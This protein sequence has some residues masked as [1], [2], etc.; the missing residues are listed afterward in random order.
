M[1]N[2]AINGFGRIGRSILRALL[3]Q[4]E[5]LREDMKHINIVAINDINDWQILS[6]LLAHDTT[7]GALPYEVTHAQNTLFIKDS[8]LP[9]IPTLN[10]ATPSEL[11]FSTFGADIV[12]ESSGQFLDMHSLEHHCQKG[13]KK[14][15][16]SAAPQDNMPMFALGVNHTLYNNEPIFSN[17]SCTANALAPLCKIID[18]HFGIDL[19]S[20]CITH[21]YTNE[22]SLLDSVYPHDKRRS[23]AAAQ[24]IIP[25]STGATSALLRLL[26]SLQGKVGGHSVRVPVSN[27]LLLDISFVLSRQANAQAINKRIIHESEHTMRGIIGI[28]RDYGVSSDFIGN[29]HSVV[30]VPDLTY[31]VSDKMVRIMAWCDN[32][33]GYANRMLDMVRFCSL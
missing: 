16:L 2:I 18:E 10:C 32:E 13:I 29:P 24:N 4:Q 3:A 21:S 12:I 11:D 22:Q 5:A 20:F 19:A 7:H 27:V 28:D 30:F 1:I 9:P 17:A 6:Y 23:R 8:P 15:I 31:M 26:P 25:T 33:W 14:V